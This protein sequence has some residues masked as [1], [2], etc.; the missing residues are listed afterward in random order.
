MEK[1]LISIVVPCYNEEETL[2]IL[3]KELNSVTETMT[4]YAF[5]YVFV[6]DGSKDK[7]ALLL[8][9]MAEKMAKICTRC[10]KEKP[11]EEYQIDR[12]GKLGRKSICKECANSE[13]REKRANIKICMPQ[14]LKKDL[15]IMSIKTQ[16]KKK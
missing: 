10:G 8:K 2:Q 14:P 5:E 4:E 7:T 13:K 1:K 6:N 11:L 15:E 12:R 9:E 3:Y 16:T